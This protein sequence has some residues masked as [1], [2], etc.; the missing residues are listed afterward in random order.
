MDLPVVR[1]RA[2]FFLVFAVLILLELVLLAYAD[3]NLS[4][5]ASCNYM[6][7]CFI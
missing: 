2:S 7:V 4:M 5:H 6:F 3:E 1:A